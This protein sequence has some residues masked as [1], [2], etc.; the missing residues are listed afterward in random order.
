[1]WFTWTEI[2]S[3]LGVSRMTIYRRR[4]EFGMLQDVRE[5][6]GARLHEVVREMR[7]EL[8][9]IGEVMMLGRLRSL[10]FRVSRD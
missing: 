3:L 9:D 7:T 2:A 6:R 8:P 1:M 4:H 5:I 10:G